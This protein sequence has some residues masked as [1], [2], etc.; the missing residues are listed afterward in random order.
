METIAFKMKL[1]LGATDEYRRR[2]DEIW[3]E[4]SDLLHELGVSD[5]SIFF[6]AETLDLFAVLN[7][8]DDHRMQDLPIH[9]VMQRW[10]T[11]MADLMETN[12]DR[13]PIVKDLVPVFYLE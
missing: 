8:A 4:L 2:H 11:Y 9:P 7:R 1:K 3:P 10:W 5:Y 12:P 13:S 6:D